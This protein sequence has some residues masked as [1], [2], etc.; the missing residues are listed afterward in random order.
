MSCGCI[1][2]VTDIP[3]FRELTRHVPGAGLYTAGNPAALAEQA[4]LALDQHVAG[5]S[6][7]VKRAFDQYL[8]YA[9]LARTYSE[10]F[11]KL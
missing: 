9:A 7:E 10:E 8:S 3:S 2:L 4:R 1:P 11:Q 6:R 5:A